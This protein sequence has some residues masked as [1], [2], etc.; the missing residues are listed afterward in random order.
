M[1]R[2][3]ASLVAGVLFYLAFVWR[4]PSAQRSSIDTWQDYLGI[5]AVA[6]LALVG[7]LGWVAFGSGPGTS[8]ES[9][10]EHLF[11]PRRWRYM[12]M[13]YAGFGAVAFTICAAGHLAFLKVFRRN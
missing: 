5:A 1:S 4:Q 10:L 13:P 7:L 11:A 2:A 3:L 12:W 9:I 6:S 8:G